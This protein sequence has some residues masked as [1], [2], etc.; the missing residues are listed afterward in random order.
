[1]RRCGQLQ[2]QT[3]TARA[4]RNLLRRDLTGSVEFLMLTDVKIASVAVPRSL[5]AHLINHENITEAS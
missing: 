5:P 4:S 3:K 1:M 2:K